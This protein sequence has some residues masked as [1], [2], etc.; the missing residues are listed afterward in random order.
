MRQRVI[1]TIA[2]CLTLALFSCGETG[3]KPKEQTDSLSPMSRAKQIK[4]SDLKY[5]LT[6]LQNRQLEFDFFGI[7]SNGIDCIY[8]VPDS[9]LYA[10]E[11]EVM[12]EGQKPWLNKLRAFAQENNY[13]TLITTYKNEPNYKSSEPA[14]VLRIETKSNLEQTATIGR[15][16]MTQIFGNSEQTIYDLVP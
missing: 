8:F 13:R 10:I 16:I 15:K 2:I 9:N 6:R 7:T 11:F 1:S 4:V 3:N 12:T 5:V 14:P